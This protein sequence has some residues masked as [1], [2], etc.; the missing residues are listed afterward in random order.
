MKVDSN[1]SRAID[2]YLDDNNITAGAFARDMKV[3]PAS[4]TKWRK[5]GSGINS[6]RWERLFPLL[7]MYLPAERIYIDDAGHERYSS[8]TRHQ[9]GYVFE[10]K[11]VPQMVPTFPLSDLSEFDDTLES[12]TQ[13]GERRRASLSEYRPRHPVAGGVFAVELTD[14][15]LAPVLPAGSKLF[16]SAGE[17]PHDACVVVVNADGGRMMIGRY[18]RNGDQFSVLDIAGGPVL[19]SGAVN[20]ARRLITWIFPVLYYEVTTF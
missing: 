15:G 10:P 5:V 18:R 17:R 14:D 4:V 12:V 11:Y 19:L 7:K 1:I 3:S 6:V 13:F 20:D 8:A 9:S 2:S 16:A